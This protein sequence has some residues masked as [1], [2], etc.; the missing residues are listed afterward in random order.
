MWTSVFWKKLIERVVT[1][2]VVSFSAY[3]AADDF[4]FDSINWKKMILAVLVGVIVSF[5][6]GMI[7][8][9][10]GNKADPGWVSEKPENTYRVMDQGPSGV[11]GYGR[12]KV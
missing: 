2:A 6:K 3:I 11:G 4:D 5:A 12:N 9:Q 10:I 7:G 8:S 1:A